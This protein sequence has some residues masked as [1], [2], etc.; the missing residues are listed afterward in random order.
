ML[1]EPIIFGACFSRLILYLSHRKR[2]CWFFVSDK[3]GFM[4]AAEKAVQALVR[5]VGS[6]LM[7]VSEWL[8]KTVFG[9][10]D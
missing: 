8:R 5:N 3:A 10:T 4:E 9:R 1:G 2:S 6:V 7:K